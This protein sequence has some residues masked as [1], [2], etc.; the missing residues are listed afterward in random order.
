MPAGAGDDFSCGWRTR[1]APLV[2]C[3]RVPPGR[4]VSLDAPAFSA[5]PLAQSMST[6]LDVERVRAEGGATLLGLLPLI[7]IGTY[8]H[9]RMARGLLQET[10]S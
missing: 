10:L 1:D 4:Y 6:Q 9:G 8:G 2:A 5:L 7:H 3:S